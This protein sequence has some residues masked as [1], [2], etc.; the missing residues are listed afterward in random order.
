MWVL[1][2][3]FGEI[4]EIDVDLVVVFGVVIVGFNIF[5][6]FGVKK[7]VDVIGVDVCDYD[8]IY[9]LLEDI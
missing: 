1:L 4:I 3:V 2:L 9:K 8:V 6:V 5:M 7:V